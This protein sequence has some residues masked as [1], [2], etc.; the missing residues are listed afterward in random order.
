MGERGRLTT[1][2]AAT[3]LA[4]G[5]A[6]GACGDSDSPAGPSTARDA[7]PSPA[8]G[9]ASGRS[10]EDSGGGTDQFLTPG[11][12]NS[13]QEFGEEAGEAD[14]E[15]AA[16]ALHAFLDARAEGDWKT[17]CDHLAEKVLGSFERFAERSE[18]LRG[19]SCPQLLA[20]VS[21]PATG[22]ARE[23]AALAD[24]GALR[25]EGERGFVLYHGSEETAWAMPMVREDGRWKVAALAGVPLA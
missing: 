20:S 6:L 9:P 25:I 24:V 12:D 19:K 13:V 2:L 14:R 16:A 3:T 4:L 17:T 11:G 7:S 22:E 18:G 8:Q 15:E 10:H 1:W 21:G 23:E 5:L